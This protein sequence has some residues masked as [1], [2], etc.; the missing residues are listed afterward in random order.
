VDDQK[1]G[2]FLPFFLLCQF[3]ATVITGLSL[4]RILLFLQILQTGLFSLIAA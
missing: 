4:F 1:G 2:T 3:L